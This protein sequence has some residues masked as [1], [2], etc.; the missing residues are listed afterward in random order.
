M[1]INLKSIS[2]NDKDLAKINWNKRIATY[3]AI[4]LDGNIIGNRKF[5]FGARIYLHI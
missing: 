1:F 2:D 5:R 4:C 3:L